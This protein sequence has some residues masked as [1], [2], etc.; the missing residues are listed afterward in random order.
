MMQFMWCQWLSSSSHRWLSVHYSVI[1]TNHGVLGPALWVSL[2]RWVT[3]KIHPASFLS[4]LPISISFYFNLTWILLFV[5]VVVVMVV[6]FFFFPSGLDEALLSLL[7]VY[8]YRLTDKTSIF[9]CKQVFLSF[10]LQQSIQWGETK[11]SE[12]I[13]FKILGYF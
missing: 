5:L 1:A 3:N 10:Y 13:A 2:R 4:F 7:L 6:L 8:R 11:K 12:I 9:I